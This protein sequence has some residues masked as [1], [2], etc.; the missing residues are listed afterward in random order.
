MKFLLPIVLCLLGIAVGFGSSK[1]VP[2]MQVALNDECTLDTT[3]THPLEV[4]EIE[5][6]SSEYL[7]LS[8]QFVVPIV[9]E[10]DVGALAVLSLSLEVKEGQKEAVFEME[11]KIRN[12]LL[13]VLFDHA[14]EGAFDGQF[15]SRNNLDLLQTRLLA[16]V[17]EATDNQVTDVLITDIVRQNISN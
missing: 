16:S 5:S 6:T 2:L 17:R 9:R 12:E 3:E 13:A 1:A 7:K 4:A 15:A 11:P 8:N 14:N 10:N